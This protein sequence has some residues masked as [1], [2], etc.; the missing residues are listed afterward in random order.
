MLNALRNDKKK[1][2]IDDLEEIL[3]KMMVGWQPNE[4]QYT[5]ALIDQI[6]IHELG[7]AVVGLLSKHHAKMTK[8]VI[9]LSSPKNPAYT[10]FENSNN[11]I[12]TREALFE[13]LMIL[14][15][16]RIGEEVVYGVS[17]STGAINDF[18]EALKLAQHM[19]CYY[20][21]GKKLI[22]PSMSEKY[23]EMIDTEVS[24]LISDAYGYSEF[25]I[26]NSKDLILEGADILKNDKVLKS[27]TLLKLMNDKYKSVLSLKL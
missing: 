25:I 13:H 5:T 22:Y 24:T 10:I 20:G 4:H 26:R 12:L 3:N 27:D 11:N 23:K 2:T 9:N 7:H 19:V 21:M 14:L 16:G 1:Y 18:E 17:V 6:A 15:A 8:V